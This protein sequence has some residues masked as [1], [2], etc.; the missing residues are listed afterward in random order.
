[1]E[2]KSSVLG[3]GAIKPPLPDP[4]KTPP[5]SKFSFGQWQPYEMSSRP[6]KKESSALRV[7]RS[8]ALSHRRN[9]GTEPTWHSCFVEHATR[10]CKVE[11]LD[12]RKVFHSCDDRLWG[13]FLIGRGKNGK[14][15]A[16]VQYDKVPETKKLFSLCCTVFAIWKHLEA[17]GYWLFSL[18]CTVLTLKRQISENSELLQMLPK[19][20]LS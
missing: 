5:F 15:S 18:F 2:F 4:L 10:S 7:T 17:F 9:S 20:I 6:M 16:T 1:M 8:G 11:K 3:R 13:R 14:Q 12:L 19:I